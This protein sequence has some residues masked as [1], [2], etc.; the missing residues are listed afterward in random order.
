MKQH[1]SLFLLFLR[2]SFWRVLLLL[3]LCGAAEWLVFFF[4]APKAASLYDA[5]SGCSA[6]CLTLSLLCFAAVSA[7]LL[8]ATVGWGK[9][10][11]R[12]TMTR[13]SLSTGWMMVW[14]GVYNTLIYLLFWWVQALILVG[15]CWFYGWQGGF[16][17]PN[18]LYVTLW[19]LPYFHALLPLGISG[20]WVCNLLLCAGLGF[21]GACFT[22]G[23]HR[24][25]QNMAFFLLLLGVVFLSNSGSAFLIVITAACV[26]G[27]LAAVWHSRKEDF[28]EE[29]DL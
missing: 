28:C 27:G 24:D 25:R 6:L 5:L 17:G 19:Q 7:L 9:N 15:L 8:W 22:E 23:L 20:G 12:Y 2:H 10:Q 14:Q 21:T 11:P 4:R 29:T 26:A 18:T 13:L 3:A 16:L 1:R